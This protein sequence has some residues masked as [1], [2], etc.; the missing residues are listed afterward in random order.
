[1]NHRVKR[2]FV[3]TRWLHH[4]EIFKLMLKGVN[5]L[6]IRKEIK[7]DKLINVYQKPSE[8]SNI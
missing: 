5:K 7:K 2:V 4:L 1:M 3:L 8:G 6:K